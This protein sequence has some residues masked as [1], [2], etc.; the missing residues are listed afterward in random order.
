M[1]N[2]FHRL[3]AIEDKDKCAFRLYQIEEKVEK[4]QKKL[5]LAKAYEYSRL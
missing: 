2:Y 1:V 4:V 5:N 3:Y